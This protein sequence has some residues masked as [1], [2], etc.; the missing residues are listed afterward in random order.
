MAI[1]I[2][3]GYTGQEH[4]YGYDW[5]VLNRGIFGKG[6]AHSRSS[7]QSRDAVDFA[8]LMLI[9]EQIGH[10]FREYSGIIPVFLRQNGF[11]R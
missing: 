7:F 4:V 3:N 11:I 6:N 2:I 5:A 8:G 10:A 9:P 1:N